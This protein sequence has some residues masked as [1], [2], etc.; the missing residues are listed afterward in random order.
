MT[1]A[2]RGRLPGD[3]CVKEYLSR[4]PLGKSAIPSP[5]V[6]LHSPGY[7]LQQTIML[8]LTALFKPARWAER[9]WAPT[10]V[11][12]PD[13]LLLLDEDLPTPRWMLE[14][15]TAPMALPATPQGR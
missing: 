11:Q 3:S 7:K 5:A 9:A 8:A 12:E 1:S 6:G 13:T 15:E 14:A 2:L 4:A 10:R